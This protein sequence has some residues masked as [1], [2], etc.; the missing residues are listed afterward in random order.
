MPSAS[1]G[2]I[3]TPPGAR[4]Q[5]CLIPDERGWP[6]ARLPAH[7]CI[8]YIGSLEQQVPI[9]SNIEAVTDRH[10]DRRLNFQI[11][12]GDVGFDLRMVSGGSAGGSLAGIRAGEHRDLINPL[13]LLPMVGKVL[14]Q[15]EA[16]RLFPQPPFPHNDKYTVA[17]TL[18]PELPVSFSILCQSP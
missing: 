11:T 12:A 9:H 4:S 2:T 7:G 10:L 13:D 14:G 3:F 8:G 18:P 16:I 1:E 17:G 5:V 6:A 15:M